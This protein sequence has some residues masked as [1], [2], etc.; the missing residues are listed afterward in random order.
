MTPNERNFLS[1]PSLR[2]LTR[3]NPEHNTKPRGGAVSIKDDTQQKDGHT[4]GLLRVS[5][6]NDDTQKQTDNTTGLLR[7][8]PSQ[9]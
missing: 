4:T 1:F 5:P 6:R 2:G 3:S 9:G 8:K 7:E